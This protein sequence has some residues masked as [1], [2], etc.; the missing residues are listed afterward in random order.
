[1]K[2]NLPRPGPAA[3]CYELLHLLSRRPMPVVYSAPEDIHK[4]L[5]LRSASL[6]EALTDPSVTLRSG[7]RRIPRAIVTGLTAE[8]RAVCMSHR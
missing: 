6:L 3:E 2:R 1:M 7:E 8:G 5:A 4:I